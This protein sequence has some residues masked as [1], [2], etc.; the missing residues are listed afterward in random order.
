[1]VVF[2]QQNLQQKKDRLEKLNSKSNGTLN[3]TIDGKPFTA[4]PWNAYVMDNRLYVEARGTGA[5]SNREIVIEFNL[6]KKQW[7]LQQ[8]YHEPKGFNAADYQ[9]TY[10]LQGISKPYYVIKTGKASITSMAANGGVIKG[11]FDFAGELIDPNNLTKKPSGSVNISS[12]SFE[13]KSYRTVS[14]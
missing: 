7:P 11:T 9:A 2:G 10:R 13:I 5:E 12:G 1:M 8:V 14:Y 3:C 6:G 4:N